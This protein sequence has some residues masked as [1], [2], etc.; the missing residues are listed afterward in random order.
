MSTHF[1]DVGKL[2]D[3]L[4]A[5]VSDAEALLEGSPLARQVKKPTRRASVR[6]SH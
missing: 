3:D 5:L 1:F 4:H 6:K 2:A